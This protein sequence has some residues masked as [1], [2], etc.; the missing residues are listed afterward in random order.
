ME[1]VRSDTEAAQSMG[2]WLF[3]LR[4]AFRQGSGGD[5]MQIHDRPLDRGDSI[6]MAAFGKTEVGCAT[7]LVNGAT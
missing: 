4:P 6:R 7:V 1:L 5:S 2:W 3:W